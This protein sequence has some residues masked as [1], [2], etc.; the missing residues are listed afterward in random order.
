MLD[1]HYGA[2]IQAIALAKGRAARLASVGAFVEEA[3]AS[4]LIQSD[5]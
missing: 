5:Q 3:R 2:N 1:G 4:G